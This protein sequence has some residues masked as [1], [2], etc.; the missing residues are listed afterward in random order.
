M[1]CDIKPENIAI[2]LEPVKA[3]LLGVGACIKESSVQDRNVR[4]TGW[5]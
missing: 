4:T 5:L 3:V 1:Q 2:P